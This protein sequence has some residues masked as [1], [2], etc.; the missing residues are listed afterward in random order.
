MYHHTRSFTYN[1]ITIRLLKLTW[2]QMRFSYSRTTLL[3]SFW[4]FLYLGQFMLFLMP[5]VCA[6][7][8][9]ENFGIKH[10]IPNEIG[11]R[12]LRVLSFCLPYGSLNPLCRDNLVRTTSRPWLIP[13]WLGSLIL[14][15]IQRYEFSPLPAGYSTVITSRIL[16]HQSFPTCLVVPC[17]SYGNEK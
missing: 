15:A 16:C 12:I 5:H 1:K 3:A 4:P 14:P 10:K 2:K 8:V 9:S 6:L 7:I 17:C 13:I 11:L